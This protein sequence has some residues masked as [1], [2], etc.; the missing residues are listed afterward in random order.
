LQPITGE[1][2]EHATLNK[3]DG[4]R[5]DV[6]MTGFWVGRCEKSYVDVK[7]FNAHAPTNHSITP[8][9]VYHRH[10]NIKKRT[11]EAQI[12]E[13]EHGMFTPLVFSATGGMA[14][15]AIVFYKHLASLLSEKRNEHY[16]IMMGWIRCCLSFSLLRSAIRYLR[17]SRSSAGK[18]AR[19]NPVDLIQ[20]E[21]GL[22]P[23]NV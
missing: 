9:A 8:R 13:V 1:S 17:G 11:Y 21:T 2:F 23:L 3:E 10:E 14:D 15:Q 20:A 5:L 6:A 16:A 7:V 18:Y 19:E 12:R 22:S 4:A